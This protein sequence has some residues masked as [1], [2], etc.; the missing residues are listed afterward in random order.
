MDSD[1]NQ[2]SHVTQTHVKPNADPP[3]EEVLRSQRKLR[4]EIIRNDAGTIGISLLLLPA[5]IYLGVTTSSPWTWYLT[6]PVLVW[7]SVFVLTY[8]SRH[9]LKP[10]EP[11]E[12]LFQCVRNSLTFVEYQIR[13]QRNFTWWYSLPLLVSLV[14][15]IV[16]VEWLKQ[17][18]DWWDVLDGLGLVA[19][20]M[21]L[22]VFLHFAT[23]YALHSKLEPRRHEL[24]TLLASDPDER[25][26]QG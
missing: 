1:S 17:P 4:S 8:R 15:Y 23:Q 11:D 10:S 21:A 25:T 9:N 26:S 13:L 5:W 14:T 7:H 6:L 16:H 22:T 12:P 19:G 2:P 20:A 24:L 3:L 18:D